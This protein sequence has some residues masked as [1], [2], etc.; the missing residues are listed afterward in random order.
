MLR[1]IQDVRAWLVIGLPLLLCVLVIHSVHAAGETISANSTAVTEL[2]TASP[3]SGI[4]I[5]GSDNS[6]VPVK[7]L[8]ANGTLSM[9][10]TSGLTFFNA[11][12]G[13]VSNPQTG[14]T[15]YF[16]GTRSDVNA[17]LATL[18]YT[19]NVTG[20][21]TLEMSL[22]N[23]GEVF[24]A[25]TGHLYEYVSSTLTWGSAK[26]AA[27][28][29]SKYGATG[30][31]ATI[32]SQAENDF[33]SARLLNAG[34]MGASDSA[35]EGAWRWVTGP[36]NGTQFCS[37]NNPCNSVSSRYTNW[38][39]GEPNDS[40]SNEDCGQFLA[41]GTGR[42]ND[43]PCS[44]TTLPG[45]VVEYGASGN[46]PAVAATNITI[47]TS[48]TVAPTTPGVPTITSP[49]TDTTPQVTWTSSTDSGTGLKNP[50]Y[51]V[52]WSTSATFASVAGSATTNSTSLSPSSGLA[53][54]SWYFRVKA[55]DNADNV[56]TS[57]ISMVVIDTTAPTTPGLPATDSL[58][59]NDTTPTWNW[60]A[61][62]D[63]GVGLALSAY[64]VQWSQ[65]ASFLTGVN[66]ASI[67]DTS[68]YTIPS[69]LAEGT[70]YFRVRSVDI[71][72]NQSS[73]SYYGTVH[74]DTTAPI[75]TQVGSLSMTIVQGMAF[76]DAGATAS[77]VAE[78]DIT[79]AIVVDD[80]V[81]INIPGDYV[82]TYN[83]TDSAGNVASTVTRTVRV[84]SNADL[85]NDN[86]AD[87]IQENV[88]EVMNTTTSKYVVAEVDDT[89][90]LSD[91][92]VIN[93]TDLRPDDSYSYPVGLLDFTANC[94]VNGFTMTVTQYYYN[95]PS[96]NF[97]LRKYMNGSFEQINDA[98][99]SRQS[100]DNIPVLVV[101]YPVTDGGARDADGVANGVIVDP[102]GPAL[103]NAPGAPNTGVAASTLLQSKSRIEV[104]VTA[105]TIVGAIVVVIVMILY[106]Y[107]KH[108]VR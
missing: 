81:N 87:A 100:I 73:W 106:A 35:S 108:R 94:G 8:V 7:L 10:T 61:S 104:P 72:G 56:A 83:V 77:D 46:M 48:D 44:G 39:T 88:V 99:I 4:S 98:V 31:L 37:G 68:S 34:W 71:L 107:R 14:S 52:E 30:Y 57:G 76:H 96:G 15:L 45:Y 101:R 86:I 5:N 74:I 84:V 54:G 58:W 69:E 60:S 21:D 51:T 92:S 64:T 13:T 47:T 95:P 79:E 65:D 67:S 103:L 27:E 23:P 1:K 85:N 28:G 36:E 105:T 3:I 49:T 40:S 43:L 102:A 50:T 66:S 6:T 63:A 16:S 22:V 24:F 41:G 93:Q 38:N 62:V 33:V 11:S 70:W 55:T 89:C 18:R 2:K 97:V 42:W 80:L 9:T 82:V 29:R 32:T 90:S 53:D 17:A 19:R 91:V 20:T 26:T 75:I 25:G 78:G 59:T 12:G